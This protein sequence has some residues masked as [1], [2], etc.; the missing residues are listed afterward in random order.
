MQNFPISVT[1]PRVASSKSQKV[2]MRVG[3]YTVEQKRGCREVYKPCCRQQ[4]GWWKGQ[5]VSESSTVRNKGAW[6]AS[7]RRK[8]KTQAAHV[9]WP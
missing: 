8:E 4:L 2:K 3:F 7:F 1:S 9:M 5:T 6:G